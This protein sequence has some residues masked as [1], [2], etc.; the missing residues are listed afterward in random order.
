M[1]TSKSLIKSAVIFHGTYGSPQGNWFPWLGNHLKTKGWDVHIPTLPT[2]KNQSLDNWKTALAEQVPNYHDADLF[3]GH[4]CGG[5]FLLR[6]LEAELVKPHTSIFVGSVT[7]ALGNQF[8]ELN[9]SFV[10]HPFDWQTIKASCNNAHVFHG[11]N[12][13][14][15]SVAQSKIIAEKLDAPF[16]LI[17]NGGHLNADSGYT[18]FDEILDCIDV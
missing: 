3:V 1:K 7:D 12:D 6:L 11:D 15:V 13:P 5:S 17:E 10:D 18:S 14:Y 4:S 16:H 9:K 2:P 8:D